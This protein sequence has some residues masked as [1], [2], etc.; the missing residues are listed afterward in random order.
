MELS[1]ILVESAHK[2]ALH[3]DYFWPIVHPHLSSDHS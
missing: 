1:F 3:R 2:A